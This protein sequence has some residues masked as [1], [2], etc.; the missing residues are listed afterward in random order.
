MDFFNF[1]L[2]FFSFLSCGYMSGPQNSLRE[3]YRPRQSAPVLTRI[4]SRLPYAI[5]CLVEEPA[6]V[7]GVGRRGRCWN[8]VFVSRA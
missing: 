8:V 5:G 1:F 7:V 6:K 4:G 2:F 3:M